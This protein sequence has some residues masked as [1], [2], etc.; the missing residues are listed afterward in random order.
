[1]GNQIKK[2]AVVFLALTLC[3]LFTGCKIE[4]PEQE[5]PSISE[6]GRSPTQSSQ[7]SAST[8]PSSEKEFQSREAES[9]PP[10]DGDNSNSNESSA[11]SS[12]KGQ[13]GSSSSGKPAPR[14]S[15]SSK[16]E[17]SAPSKKPAAP[18]SSEQPEKKLSCTFLITCADIL[19]HMDELN[20]AKIDYIPKD[21]VIYEK[22]TVVFEKGESVFDVIRRE[23]R[24][25]GILMEYSGS[26][27]MAYIEGIA[28]IYEG[29]CGDTS[30]WMYKVNGAAP[31]I[32]CGGYTLKD[33]DAVEWIFSCEYK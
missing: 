7:E 17:A 5:P 6:S 21:G 15:P 22:R 2:S 1:M 27:K 16:T 3:T 28:N 32:G 12:S 26:P 9:G 23:T 19:S 24:A 13:T 20:P 10:F 18:S 11:P 33:G 14:P 8:P 30:G 31:S 29:D 4:L 25:A